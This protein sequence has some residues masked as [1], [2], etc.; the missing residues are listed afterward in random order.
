MPSS[1]V[2]VSTAIAKLPKS[3]LFESPMSRSLVATMPPTTDPATPRR[4][5]QTMP[6]P[7]R[8]GTS[9]RAI[10]P[11]NKPQTTH[12]TTSPIRG[13]FSLRKPSNPRTQGADRAAARPR[14]RTPECDA[15]QPRELLPLDGAG[16]L[17][18]DVQHHPVHLRDLVD[19][20]RG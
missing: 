17:R 10:A 7:C 13:W 19:H 4:T 2:D 8:P 5:V 3:K 18:R 11:T 14:P 16:W 15:L 20:P 6:I 1:S 9:A 12:E